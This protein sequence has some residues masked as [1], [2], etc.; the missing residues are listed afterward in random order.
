MRLRIAEDGDTTEG[1]TARNVVSPSRFLSY[2]ERRDSAVA[3]GVH[4]FLPD[5]KFLQGGVYQGLRKHFKS[6]VHQ[7]DKDLKRAFINKH[8]WPHMDTVANGVYQLGV[9]MDGISFRDLMA[10]TL[11]TRFHDIGYNFPLG[12]DPELCSKEQ[13]GQHAQYG[14]DRFVDAINSMRKN[15]QFAEDLEEWTDHHTQIAHDAIRMHSNGSSAAGRR[16]RRKDQNLVLLPRLIDKLDNSS[17]RV[18]EEHVRLFSYVP[19]KTLRHIH[20]CVRQRARWMLEESSQQ[21]HGHSKEETLSKL[22]SYEHGFPHRLVPYAI[23]SQRM[24]LLPNT[25]QIEVQYA[26]YPSQVE[27]LLGIPYSPEDHAGHFDAAYE[28]SMQNAAAVV[29]LIRGQLFGDAVRT[30][31]PPLR[32]SLIYPETTVVKEY[33]ATH[34]PLS[35]RRVGAAS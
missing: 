6:L 11:A 4:K 3:I 15:Q 35:T 16:I 19:H 29:A 32:V 18:Y 8:S 20:Q 23:A 27:N 34:N 21:R 1:R 25:G 2:E 13:H 22:A 10:A 31:T 33:E 26:A 9:R 7:N 17:D 28:K 12:V 24:V 5:I 30:D 14:A